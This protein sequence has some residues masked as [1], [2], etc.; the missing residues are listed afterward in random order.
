M[1]LC[2]VRLLPLKERLT[3]VQNETATFAK[4]LMF[5]QRLLSAANATNTSA[6]TAV[7]HVVSPSFNISALTL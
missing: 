1:P 7:R 2:F 3:A 4:K 6:F 5:I